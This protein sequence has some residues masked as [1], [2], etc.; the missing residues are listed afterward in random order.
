MHFGGGLFFNGLL[1]VLFGI[2]ILNAPELLAYFVAILLLI[3]GTWLL[4]MW[5]QMRQ[6]KK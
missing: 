2:A 5:W 4:T 1:C 3:L 6:W